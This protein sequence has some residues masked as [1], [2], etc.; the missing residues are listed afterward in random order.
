LLSVS[1]CESFDAALVDMGV[2]LD[3]KRHGGS[4]DML[5][6]A[7]QQN[8]AK[9][10][11]LPVTYMPLGLGVLMPDVITTQNLPREDIGPYELRGESL[12]GALQ[13]I[14]SEFDI[15]LAVET[16]LATARKVTIANLNG[17]L[18]LMVEQLCAMSD[19]YCV[20]K[21]GVL[22]IQP[23]HDYAV[24][25][26]PSGATVDIIDD[27]AKAIEDVT[28]AD[29][30]VDRATRTLV[31]S[32]SRKQASTLARYFEKLRGN[33]ALINYEVG[34][35]SVQLDPAHQQGVYWEAL[36]DDSA[37]RAG[38]IAGLYAG[39]YGAPVSI[40]LPGD[41]GD[42]YGMYDISKFLSQFGYVK[43]LSK[44]SI[45]VMS[46]ANGLW[47]VKQ[48]EAEDGEKLDQVTIGLS[49]LW[50]GASVFSDLNLELDGDV[51]RQIK[52]QIR[53]RPG[54]SLILAGMMR[55]RADGD[56]RDGKALTDELVVMLRP[57]VVVYRARKDYYGVN[58]IP[59]ADDAS[60]EETDIWHSIGDEPMILV[61]EA[62]P[63]PPLPAK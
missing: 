59:R 9:Q 36:V 16:D 35:W 44:P 61:P 46:G 25:I 53:I 1:A 51:E 15:P 12:A 42:A 60:V 7:D 57:R 40:G 24:T 22:S 58:G 62:A 52:T 13:F 49:S 21:N 33:M 56:A 10:K 27:V 26:P 6:Q 20:Y 18:D 38:A 14:L 11:I 8:S 19:L 47:H 32:S 45:S 41:V 5:V 4:E 34:I 37:G 30:V 39:E 23:R 17:R 55:Q 31:Y 2:L 54:D 29:V 63:W 50:D 48:N 43:A 3:K 28:K